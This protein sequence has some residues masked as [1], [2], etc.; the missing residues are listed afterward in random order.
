VGEGE[1][2]L[3]IH[4]VVVGYDVPPSSRALP[5]VFR[6]MLHGDRRISVMFVVFDLLA[7]S[8]RGRMDWPYWQRRERLDKLNLSSPWWYPPEAFHEGRRYLSPFLPGAGTSA[9][10]PRRS[11]LAG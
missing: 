8:G 6:R 4:G 11:S 9:G 7:D 1:P 3:L 2:L 5:V 10:S